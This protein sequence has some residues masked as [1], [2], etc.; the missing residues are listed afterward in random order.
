MVSAD[1]R[2]KNEDFADHHINHGQQKQPA[3]KTMG[4]KPV[5][6]GKSGANTTKHQRIKP[7]ESS[8][9]SAAAAGLPGP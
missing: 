3:R 4:D 8:N 1:R 9:N 6:L 2:H 7:Q 5:G